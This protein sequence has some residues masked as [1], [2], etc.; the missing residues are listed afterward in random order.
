MHSEVLQALDLHLQ[1]MTSLRQNLVAKRPITPGER[2]RLAADALSCAEQC[3]RTLNGLLTG[4][5]G[6]GDEHRCRPGQGETRKPVLSERVPARKRS[7]MRRRP[8]DI[9]VS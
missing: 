2:R 6:D 7:P 4:D 5:G 3:A 9:A 1:Q 8:A